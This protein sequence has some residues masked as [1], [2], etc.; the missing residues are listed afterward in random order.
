MIGGPPTDER[1]T[2][3][4]P[5][6][7]AP[8]GRGTAL[9]VANCSGFYGDRISAMREV[10]DGGLASATTV[11]VITGDYL[12]ELTMLILGKDQLRDPSLGYARTFVTQLADCLGDALERGVRIVANAGGLNP[13]GLADR[14]AEVA[15]G[16]GLDPAIGFVDGDDLAPRAAELGF[17]GALTANAYLGGF[18]IA[19]ALSAGADVVVTGRVTD[20]SVVVGPGIWRFGWTPES[21]DELAGAVI[22]GHVIECGT[23]ATGGNFSGFTD[24]PREATPLGFPIAELRADGSSV[25]TKHPGTGGVVTIDTVT[26]QLMY[27][28]QGPVYDNPDVRADLTSISLSDDGPDRVL[29]DG[30]RGLPAPERLKVSTN[31]LGGYR[32]QMEFVLVGLHLAEKEAWIRTQLD[33]ALA[34][35]PPAEVVWSR[36]PLPPPD[37]DTEEGASCRLRCVVKDASAEVVGKA[38]TA[39]GIEL[40]LASYPGFTLT[41]PP[42]KPS[43]YGVYRPAYVDR[44]QVHERVVVGGRELDAD[45]YAEGTDR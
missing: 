10:L 30:V 1:P 32:N 40:A 24:L 23:H 43:A 4:S 36:G 18:G 16:L 31:T 2:K 33:A 38:F 29:I 7:R 5:A 14:I 8:T 35:N 13:S 45:S 42:G 17:E 6:D 22:A 37:A 11:D 28:I 41:A 39:A 3:G 25:I 19:A 21:L 15:K 44:D 12:A 9:R 20:A 34:A 26:A 27:E